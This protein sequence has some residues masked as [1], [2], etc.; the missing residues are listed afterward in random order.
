[1][2]ASSD[3]RAEIEAHLAKAALALPPQGPIG[4]FVAQNALAG[5]EDRPFLEAVIEAGRLF[6][7]EPFLPESQYRDA[8]ATGRIRPADLEAVLDGDPSPAADASLAG[9]RITRRQLHLALLLHPL[10]LED[11]AAVRWTLTESDLVARETESGLW[12]AGLEAVAS[13][14]PRSFPRAC[15][16]GTAT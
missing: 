7:A 15:R 5:F 3:R 4:V 1:M 16:C 10:R 8:L 11:D 14:A 6:Q 13:R 12:P 2:T 9:G